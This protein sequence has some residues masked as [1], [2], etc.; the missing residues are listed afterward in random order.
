VP[1]RDEFGRG[2]R[3]RVTLEPDRQQATV[4]LGGHDLHYELGLPKGIESRR[5]FGGVPMSVTHRACQLERLNSLGLAVHALPALRDVDTIEDLRAVAT[6]LGGS[7][8]ADVVA[9]LD[10]PADSGERSCGTSARRG[11]V[12]PVS[13]NRGP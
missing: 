3:Q 4:D 8:T 2:D 11:L 6:A 12:G 10:T 13:P 1:G 7:M 9:L 5:V